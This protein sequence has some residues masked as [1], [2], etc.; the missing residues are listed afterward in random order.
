[1]VFTLGIIMLYA[2]SLIPTD[3]IYSLDNFNRIT[4]NF[5]VID[6]NLNKLE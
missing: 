6:S 2:A 3:D 1:V 4:I 5:D